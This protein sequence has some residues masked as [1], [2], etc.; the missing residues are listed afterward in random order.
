MNDY[1]FVNKYERILPCDGIISSGYGSREL[2]GRRK[3]HYGI[4][5]KAPKGAP[6][7]SMEEGRVI[8]AG[9]KS[10]YGKTIIIDHDNE[11]YTLYAHNSA[12]LVDQG[13]YVR[14]GQ[15]ISKI[16]STGRST[17]PHLHYEIRIKDKPVDPALAKHLLQIKMLK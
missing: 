9:N 17:G 3:M 2:F 12:L 11:I 10:G 7:F 14:H 13:Q 1:N 4:D 6:V 5:Y 8:F 15:V 16:G